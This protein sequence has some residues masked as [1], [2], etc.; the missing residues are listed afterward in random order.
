[1]HAHHPTP[2]KLVHHYYAGR[3]ARS[4]SWYRHHHHRHWVYEVRF[5]SRAWHERA[6]ASHRAAATFSHYLAHHH[7]QRRMH[8]PSEGLWVVSFRSTHGHHYGTY[9]SLPVA[10]R[11]EVGLRQSGFA[12]WLHWHRRYF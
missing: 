8:H 10:R 4:R 3:S 6:F 1:V 7:F 5:R 12:A 2:H 9:A 11:V